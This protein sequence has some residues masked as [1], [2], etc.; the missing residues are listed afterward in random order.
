MKATTPK[1]QKK[2]TAPKQAAK[3]RSIMASAS[4]AAA[5]E[6]K[7]IPAWAR[8]EVKGLMDALSGR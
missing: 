1:S 8:K 5:Q 2:S 3:G 4:A 7:A 6:S